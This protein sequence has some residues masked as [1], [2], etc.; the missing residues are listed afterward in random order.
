MALLSVAGP[1]AT[2]VAQTAKPPA[3]TAPAP[4]T[5]PSAP[6]G[7]PA[8]APAPSATTSAP[9]PSPP[10]PA[11]TVPTATPTA[12]PAAEAAT[13]SSPNTAPAPDAAP[14][15]APPPA[16]AEQPTP[17]PMLSVNTPPAS[18]ADTGKAKDAE[19]KDPWQD[20]HGLGIEGL[21]RFQSRFGSAND[22]ADSEQ[23]AGL[24]FY[25]GLWLRIASEYAIGLILKR[26]DLGSLALTEGATTMNAGY[27]STLLELGGRAYPYRGKNGEVFLGLRVGMAWQ[28]VEATGLRPSINLQPAQPFTCSDVS[29]PG[30]ALGADLGGAVRLT[31][32]LWLT[33]GLGFDGAHMTSERVGDCVAGIGSITALSFGGGLLYTFDIGGEAKVARGPSPRA[34]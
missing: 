5:K 29:G 17:A 3:A 22:L 9:A 19:S 14:A 10:P 16:P 21:G 24:G 6:A 28:D 23:R 11:S 20:G 33:G 34:F 1:A 26:N 27:A 12:A 2:A 32:P 8:P 13:E 15:A 7:T 31:R 18:S 30:F 25:L 4:T